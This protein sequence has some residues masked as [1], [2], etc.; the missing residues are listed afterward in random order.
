MNA[1]DLELSAAFVEND[2]TRPLLTGEIQPQGIR[3]RGSALYPTE[4]FWR[5]LH[6]ADFDI[7]DMSLSSFMIAT[8][9]GPTGWVGIPAFTMRRFFHTGIMIRVDRG[10][11]TPADLAG[12]KV[13]V[14]EFQQSAALW[15]RGVLR[16][17]FR[18]EP[19]SMEW[20]MER[21]PEQSHGSATG[22]VPPPG[23]KF[24]Y[25]PRDKNNAQM[26]VD[27]ELDAL[28]HYTPGN[29]IID[30]TTIDPLRSP[31]VR[32]LFASPLAE[33]QRYFA[34]TGIYPANHLIVMRKSIA[35]CY[36]WAVLNVFAA[37]EASK[38]RLARSLTSLLE[39][40]RETGAVD[41]AAFSAL[42]HDVN[43][44]GIKAA[45][46]VLETLSEY[47]FRDGLT[48]RRVQLDEIFAKQTLD[49]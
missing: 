29:N 34:K 45:R 6:H 48:E 23:L 39:P 2:L 38:K 17:E 36:P 14:P 40:Y 9:K 19:S 42:Q 44:N 30:R 37:F 32:R 8:S 13:G 15:T 10:I 35:E 41:A 26:L 43:P 27:G 22:F 7:S 49:L 5:Q 47:L 16:D 28:I 11:T 21:S 46:P 24:N 1:A 18:V 25:I 12:K 31:M 20:F 33:G 3:L 4:I